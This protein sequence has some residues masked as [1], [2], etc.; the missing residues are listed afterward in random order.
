MFWKYVLNKK[1][2]PDDYRKKANMN[3]LHVD[4]IQGWK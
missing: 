3:I 1:E 4:N 2:K